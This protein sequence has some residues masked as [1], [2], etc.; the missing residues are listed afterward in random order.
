MSKE[1]KESEKEFFLLEGGWVCCIC[2]LNEGL[3]LGVKKWDK[4][5][6]WGKCRPIC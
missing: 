3:R 5:K 1:L 2:G 6:T 4:M